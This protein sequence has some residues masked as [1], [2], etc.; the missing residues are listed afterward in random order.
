MNR[1]E[2]ALYIDVNQLV[3]VFF[4]D[5]TEGNEFTDTGIGEDNIDS[6]LHFADCLVKTI[7]IGQFGDVSLNA[8]RVAADCL[9]GLIQFLLAT[10]R[11]EDEG[12]FF[13]E[14][15]C[16]SKSYSRG[17]TGYDGHFSLQLA[18]DR[19]SR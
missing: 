6:S 16:R 1:E 9:H 7:K 18:H 15:L 13:D 3:K 2:G 11:D 17:A 14:K 12:A 10:A 5:F 4:G 8:C 19:Y